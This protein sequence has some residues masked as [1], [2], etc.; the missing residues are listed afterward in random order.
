MY[1]KFTY[2]NFILKYDFNGNYLNINI[3]NAVNNTGLFERKPYNLVICMCMCGAT[4]LY[5]TSIIGHTGY[6]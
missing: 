3:M 2:F 5:C 4:F 6:Y 1:I